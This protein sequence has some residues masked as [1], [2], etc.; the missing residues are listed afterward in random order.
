MH[1]K[2]LYDVIPLSVV[3]VLIDYFNNNPHQHR[4][5]NSMIKIDQPWTVSAIRDSL[6]EV[7][8]SYVDVD[9]PNLGDNLYKH[10]FPYFPHVDLENG[11]PCFNCLIPLFLSN[12]NPQHF[13]IFDQYVTDV[14]NGKTWLGNFSIEGNFEANKKRKFPYS[15]SIVKNLTNQ[16]IDQEFYST[17]LEHEYRDRELFKGMT[18]VA[19]DYKP[20]NLILFDSKHIHCTGKMNNNYK[21]GL[22]LRFKG[23]LSEALK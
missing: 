23:I 17:Y 7:L 19:T 6:Y 11:Y 9:L 3:S 4:T 12:N 21:I 13:V 2:V 16:D 15:D 22:S 10:S 1:Y 20:G 5:T 18:G 14:D 8:N